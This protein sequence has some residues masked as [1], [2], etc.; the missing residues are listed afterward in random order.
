MN[1]YIQYKSLNIHLFDK[2][3]QS[4][5]IRFYSMAGKNQI[6]SKLKKDWAIVNVK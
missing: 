3:G 6:E 1:E 4:K 5:I 2:A